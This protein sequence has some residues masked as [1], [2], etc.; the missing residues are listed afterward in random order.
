[1]QIGYV[2]ISTVDQNLDLQ[3]DALKNA[4]CEKIITDEISGSLS[5]RVGLKELLNVLRKGYEVVVWRLDRLGRSLKHLIEMIN[6]FH[7]IQVT[8]TSL[9]EL[10][11][12]KS[13]TG[14]L[15][16]HIFGA[17]KRI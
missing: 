1:M 10:I 7:E 8:F 3:I 2:R 4:G 15:I 11:N 16:F 17:F 5:E 6:K 12:T 9:Q 14:K 13:S